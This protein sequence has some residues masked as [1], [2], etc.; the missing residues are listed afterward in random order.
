MDFSLKARKRHMGE[1]E[2]NILQKP[3]TK[4][5]GMLYIGDRQIDYI[6]LK[7]P[8]YNNFYLTPK[9]IFRFDLAGYVGYNETPI[10]FS[11]KLTLPKKENYK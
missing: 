9:G 1:E 11:P 10:Y 5:I 3:T 4:K 2:M 7:K 8:L 6:N